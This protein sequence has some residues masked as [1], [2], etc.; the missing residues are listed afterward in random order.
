M[1]YLTVTVPAVVPVK[2]PPGE[3]IVAAPVP[4]STDQVP[5]PLGFVNAGV[6]DPTQTVAAPPVIA[7]GVCCTA[8]LDVSIKHPEG[9]VYL[10][11]TFPAVVPVKIPPAVILA[12]PPAGITDQVP[13]GV[14]L[15]KAGVET[16]VQ[17]VAAPP[18]IAAGAGF[19][20]TL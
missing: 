18:P 6:D 14:A 4:L 2:T 15:V 17:T 19:T 12:V 11:L 16:P 3:V 1:V 13:P 9:S 8:M 7:P 20:V 5:P 10:T